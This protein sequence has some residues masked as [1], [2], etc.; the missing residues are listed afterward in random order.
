MATDAECRH[1]LVVRRVDELGDMTTDP[2]SGMTTAPVR[3]SHHECVECGV[4]VTLT[5]KEEVHGGQ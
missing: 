5:V 2:V 1:D 4:H 3:R